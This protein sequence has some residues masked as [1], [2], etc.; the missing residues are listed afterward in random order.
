MNVFQYGAYHVVCQSVEMRH[1]VAMGDV[2]SEMEGFWKIL[3]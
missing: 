2:L 1:F 3:I